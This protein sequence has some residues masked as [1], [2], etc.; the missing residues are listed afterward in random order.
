MIVTELCAELR[1]LFYPSGTH[2]KERFVSSVKLK[3]K[4]KVKELG[5]LRPESAAAWLLPLHYFGFP[6]RTIPQI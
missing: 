5:W 1:D 4:V 2:K 3:V 6:D